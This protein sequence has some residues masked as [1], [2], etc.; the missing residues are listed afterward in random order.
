MQRMIVLFFLS[1]FVS[2]SAAAH[3]IVVAPYLQF[4][5]PTSIK[6]LWETDEAGDSSVEWGPTAALGNAVVADSV[7]GNGASRIHTAVLEGLTP[8]TTIRS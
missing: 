2:S 7:T 4:A 5:E 6:V 1:G 3:E 8:A